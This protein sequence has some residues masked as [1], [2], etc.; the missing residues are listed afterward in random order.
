MWQCKKKKYTFYDSSAVYFKNLS[1]NVRPK[2]HKNPFHFI[3]KFKM[4]Y[5]DR[6]LEIFDFEMDPQFS[7]KLSAKPKGSSCFS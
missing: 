1:I 3:R 6:D 2:R 7:R 4:Q 5:V